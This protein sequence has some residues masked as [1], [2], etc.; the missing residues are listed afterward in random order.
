[1]DNR[2]DF[3]IGKVEFKFRVNPNQL[4][5]FGETLQIYKPHFL[6]LYNRIW[7]LQVNQMRRHTWGPTRQRKA[8]TKYSFNRSYYYNWKQHRKC[9]LN[10]SPMSTVSK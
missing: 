1:M 8:H 7:T 9:V 3:G 6:Y 2:K 5:N 4:G 10:M